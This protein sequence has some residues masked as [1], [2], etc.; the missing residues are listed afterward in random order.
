[1][2]PDVDDY[3]RR[4]NDGDQAICILLATEIERGLPMAKGVSIEPMGLQEHRQKERTA[5]SHPTESNLT[6]RN[7]PAE[8]DRFDREF[9]IQR[10]SAIRF[11]QNRTSFQNFA[12][13]SDH[14]NDCPGFRTS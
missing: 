4:L 3:N 12:A 9:Q 11:E 13:R 6:E 7:C 14:Q 10:L 8:A 5:G 1:M 2:S